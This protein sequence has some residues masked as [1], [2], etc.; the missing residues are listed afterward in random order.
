MKA[1]TKLEADALYINAN[2]MRGYESAERYIATQGPLEGTA[3]M[4]WKMVF[5]HKSAV[6]VM[7]TKCVEGG[8]SKCFQYWPLEVTPAPTKD[9]KKKRTSTSSSTPAPSDGQKFGDVHVRLLHVEEKANYIV[10]KL[11]LKQGKVTRTLTHFQF[12]SVSW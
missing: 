12:I 3:S 7:L 2:Y 10:R 11:E 6:V 4:F 8:K 5:E 9:E 1:K